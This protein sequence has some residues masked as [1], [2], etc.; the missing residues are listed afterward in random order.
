MIHVHSEAC[1]PQSIVEREI[2]LEKDHHRFLQTRVDLIYHD[3]H[4]VPSTHLCGNAHLSVTGLLA[5]APEHQRPQHL[6]P[7]AA[8]RINEGSFVVVNGRALPDEID[9]ERRQQLGALDELPAKEGDGCH[10]E[11]RVVDEEIVDREGREARVSVAEDDHGHPSSTEPCL[12][13]K[14]SLCAERH[15]WLEQTYGVWLE[16][17]LVGQG[18]SVQGLCLAGSIEEDVGDTHDPVV[19]DTSSGDQVDEPAQDDV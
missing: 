18:V 4:K 2:G 3:E 15:G 8:W 11:E 13:K 12:T 9:L 5:L 14:I 10:Q 16:P 7:E 19:D 17:T 6:G 1:K